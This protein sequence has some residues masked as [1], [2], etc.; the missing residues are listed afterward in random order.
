MARPLS[1]LLLAASLG[2]AATPGMTV[3]PTPPRQDSISTLTAATLARAER[4][5]IRLEDW[6]RAADALRTEEARRSKALQAYLETQQRLT[7]ALMEADPGRWEGVR[8]AWQGRELVKLLAEWE[9][10]LSSSNKAGTLEAGMTKALLDALISA[11]RA[12]AAFDKSAPPRPAKGVWDKRRDS[13]FTA[14]GAQQAALGSLHLASQELQRQ[15]EARHQNSDRQLAGIKR[16]I[17]VLTPPSA[18]PVAKGKT[19]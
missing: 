14:V 12:A 11:R 16:L 3:E 1:I 7:E 10:A 8:G 17:A 6:Q 9:T 18:A 15:L 19:P 4:E 13:L 2:L 5:R